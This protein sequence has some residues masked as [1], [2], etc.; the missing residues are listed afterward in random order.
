MESREIQISELIRRID[1]PISRNEIITNQ[2]TIEEQE[3]TK[4]SFNDTVI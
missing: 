2:T 3:E 4:E 1:D